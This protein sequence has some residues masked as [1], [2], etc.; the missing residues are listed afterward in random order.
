M[1]K[2]RE[3]KYTI[4]KWQLFGYA[5]L[6]PNLFGDSDTFLTLY[7][8]LRTPWFAVVLRKIEGCDNPKIQHTHGMVY[9]TV[10]LRGGYVERR[11]REERIR[12][13]GSLQLFRRDDAHSIIRLLRNPTWTLGFHCRWLGMTAPEVVVDGQRMGIWEYFKVKG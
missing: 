6:Q 7:P 12:W 10:V 13:V 11:G 1:T 5:E 4:P 3:R 9:G 8:L 2:I